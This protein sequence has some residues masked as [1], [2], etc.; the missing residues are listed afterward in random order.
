M[1][2]LELGWAEVGV[3]AI[4]GCALTLFFCLALVA[5]QRWHGRFTHDGTRGVQKF[6]KVPTPR[7]GGAGPRARLRAALAGAARGAAPGLGADRPRRR[8]RR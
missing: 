5:T 2:G 8:C 4:A 3:A 1:S 7:I 6:H